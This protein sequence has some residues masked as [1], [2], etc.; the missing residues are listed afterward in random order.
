MKSRR[1]ELTTGSAVGSPVSSSMVEAFMMELGD[2]RLSIQLG[3]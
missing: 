1:D 3:Q 2:C